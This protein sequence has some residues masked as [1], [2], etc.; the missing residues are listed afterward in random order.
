MPDPYHLGALRRA[1]ERRRRAE[2]GYTSALLKARDAGA[3]LDMIG[4]AA[5]VTRQTIWRAIE[6]ARSRA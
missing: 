2:E 3:S 5:G 6:R 4:T 1:A